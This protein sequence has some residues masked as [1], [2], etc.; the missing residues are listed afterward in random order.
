MYIDQFGQ[1]KA[2]LVADYLSLIF[3][4]LTKHPLDAQKLSTQVC[5][6]R[7]TR[8]LQVQVNVKH[9]EAVLIFCALEIS[10]VTCGGQDL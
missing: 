6:Y 3:S 10:A 9:A 5:L 8:Q 4:D 1:P 2:L 7:N